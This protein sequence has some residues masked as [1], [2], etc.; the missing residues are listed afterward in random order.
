MDRFGRMPVLVAGFLVG[1]SGAFAIA[2]AAA[3]MQTVPLVL[4]LMLLGAGNGSVMLLR[5]AAADLFP[6][7]RRARGIG[8]VLMG[9]VVGALLGPAVFMPLFAGKALNAAAGVAVDRRRWVFVAWRRRDVRGAT[10]PARGRTRVYTGDGQCVARD[11]GELAH[12]PA[13]PRRVAGADRDAGEC[14]RDGGA[15]DARGLRQ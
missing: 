13:A 14:R 4:G 3:R 12:D 11:D 6:S 7:A 1:A 10:G 5:L 2:F 15:D 9:A 8:L